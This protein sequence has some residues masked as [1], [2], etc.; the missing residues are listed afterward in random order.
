MTVGIA[1]RAARTL[2][3]AAD[4]AGMRG[5][6]PFKLTYVVTDECSCRCAICR[7]WQAPRAGATGDEIEA[8]FAA[9]PALS[10]INLSGG[11]VVERDD[12]AAVVGAAI[13]HTRCAALD[14]PTAGQRPDRVVAGVRAA[15]SAGA[16]RLFVTVSLDG[17]PEV[18]DSLRGTAG[19]FARALETIREL[20]RLR[21]RRLTIA[22]GLT[23]SSRNA[24]DPDATV[25]ALLAAAP[26]LDRRDL[27]FNLAHHAPHYY[28]NRPGDRP[29]PAMLPSL[30]A[31]FAAERARRGLPRSPLDLLE[32]AYWRLAEDFLATGRT[33]L[34]C[35]AL[36]SSVYLDP[37]LTVYPCAT[38]DHP[39]GNLRD[40]DYSLARALAAPAAALAR[41]RAEA[42]DCPNCWT[43]C[44]A[45]PTILS[46]KLD[47]FAACAPS[48][49]A[50]AA[51]VGRIAPPASSGGGP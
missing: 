32:L 37:D 17:P 44:E 40:H 49:R 51:G 10:W 38:W 45:Y 28:R 6:G 20:R 7:L 1:A 39:L 23:F 8:V 29:D 46:R 42:R 3:F 21:A 43:P 48:E 13:G 19:A 12:F 11:E 27:H 18:H 34:P 24:R 16:P 36:A 41:R 50:G 26:E 2:R 15:L 4:L 31:F 14:F 35:S 25:G 22:V 5:A 47:A 30:R 9:N 33:P